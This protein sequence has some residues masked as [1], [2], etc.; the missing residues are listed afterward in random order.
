MPLNKENVG[1]MAETAE[2]IF[3]PKH[4]YRYLPFRN[5]HD[6]LRRALNCNEW[7][8]G[9]RLSF[10]DQA[11][12]QIP[13]VIVDGDQVRQMA[14]A[15]TETIDSE[16]EREIA[17]FLVDPHAEEKVTKAVQGFVDRVGMLC[18]SAT[19]NDQEMWNLYA[20]RGRGVCICFEASKLAFDS[21]FVGRGPFQVRYSDDQKQVW[22]PRRSTASQLAQTEDHLFR[23]MAR[24][25]YQREWRF[26]IIPDKTN[27]STVGNHAIPFQALRAVIFGTRLSESERA[28]IE[29]WIASGPFK[30][31]RLYLPRKREIA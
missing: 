13:G 20:D 27:E 29:S 18:L 16:S 12:C 11:D 10:D 15:S 5:Q 1:P 28:E 25:S 8:F 23:K 2:P 30:A 9:S 6:S 22:D 21:D 24:W 14:A 3:L 19:P 7:W 17:S 31:D 26:V 4:L